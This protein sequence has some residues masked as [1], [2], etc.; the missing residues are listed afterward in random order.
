MQVEV[1]QR[2]LHGL[3]WRFRG[4]PRDRLLQIAAAATH[5]A[6][7][8]DSVDRNCSRELAEAR[9]ARRRL[10]VAAAVD[11]LAS[12]VPFAVDGSWRRFFAPRLTLHCGVDASQASFAVPINGARK[13]GRRMLAAAFDE[14]KAEQRQLVTEILSIDD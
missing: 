6:A 10:D 1:T 13:R 9:I 7:V 3:A 2:K 8:A 11:F 5:A 12:L 4:L 14:G